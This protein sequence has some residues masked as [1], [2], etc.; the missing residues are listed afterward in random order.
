MRLQLLVLLL[1]LTLLLPSGAADD[2]TSV[3]S[4]NTVLS[5]FTTPQLAPGESGDF[6]FVFTNPNEN[7]MTNIS[8]TMAIY[9]Y[10]SPS[11]ERLVDNS[12]STP[13]IQNNLEQEFGFPAFDLSGTVAGNNTRTMSVRIVTSENTKHGGVFEQGAYFV[14]FWLEFDYV[15]ET[16]PRS[17]IFGSR[18]HFTDQEWHDATN[19]TNVDNCDANYTKGDLCLTYLGVDGIIPDSSF[20]VKEPMPMWPFWVIVFFIGL[21]A[22]LGLMFYLEEN[23][24]TWPWVEQRWR[25][26][27]GIWRQTFQ[28]PKRKE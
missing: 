1:F 20:G 19:D 14:R 28:K 25:R 16:G 11:E 3:E 24:G 4:A 21:F 13:Y 22:F 17:Y 6:S 10:K 23:P 26:F 12:W 15:N 27:R 18:G 9:M 2:P 5:D 7:S 8:L